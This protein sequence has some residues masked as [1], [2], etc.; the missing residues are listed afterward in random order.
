MSTR[1]NW[2]FKISWKPDF[3]FTIYFF[4]IYECA[5]KS[6]DRIIQK[7]KT[8]TYFFFFILYDDRF[9]SSM[10]LSHGPLF[11]LGGTLVL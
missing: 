2:Q 9:Q 4:L 10:L 5:K 3:D 8:P 11:F 6:R 1:S 7:Q